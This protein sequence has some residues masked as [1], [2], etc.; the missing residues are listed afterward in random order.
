MAEE[1]EEKDITSLMEQNADDVLGG[2]PISTEEG[3]DNANDT[4]ATAE[5]GGTTEQAAASTDATDTDRDGDPDGPGS[6]EDA[7]TGADANKQGEPE[8]KAGS[9]ADDE[10]AGGAA[11]EEDPYATPEG[12]SE[13]AKERFESL[14]TAVKAKEETISNFKTMLDETGMND[15][16]IDSS[17][18]LG[19]LIQTQPIKAIEVLQRLTA[20]M[21]EANGVVLEGQ[22][23]LTGF[24][25][26][27]EQVEN[28]EITESAAKELASA[29]R[30]QAVETR[31]QQAAALEQQ[32]GA[33][34]EQRRATGQ[35]Q[36]LQFLERA[37][38]E[39]DYEAAA[40]QL[41]KSAQ[42]AKDNLMP[43]Q[44]ASFMAQQY[45]QI[46]TLGATPVAGGQPITE[47]GQSGAGSKAP[48]TLEELADAML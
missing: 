5:G 3:D 10:V 24:D 48:E 31:R 9:E 42:Y 13:R 12:L 44:W 38:T 34:Y 11:R 28:L 16:Q 46:K 27:R 26:L 25:D 2:D 19:R 23:P 45:A 20:S 21:A 47:Q 35:A 7:S 15:Q 6:D 14:V 4:D 32:Q 8:A 33:Q 40:P 36:V 29:R 39:I 18:Q 17:L 41:L 30:Q 37:S 1:T 43:E 22:D